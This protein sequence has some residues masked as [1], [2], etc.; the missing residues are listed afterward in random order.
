MRKKKGVW[1]GRGGT[2]EA[3]SRDLAYAHIVD[4]HTAEKLDGRCLEL[5]GVSLWRAHQYP[6]ARLGVLLAP[7]KIYKKTRPAG[8][9]SPSVVNLVKKSSQDNHADLLLDS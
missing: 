2:R 8:R 7:K 4:K 1:G 6:I 5:N 9:P 3:T